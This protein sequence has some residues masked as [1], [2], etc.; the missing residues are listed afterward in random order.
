MGGSDVC[1]CF[2]DAELLFLF[3]HMDHFPLNAQ[4]GEK[5]NILLLERKPRIHRLCCVPPLVLP[6][7]ASSEEL[8]RSQVTGQLEVFLPERCLRR[9]HGK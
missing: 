2:I 5:Q 1:S 4:K 8:L 3:Q 9:L 7:L 6:T